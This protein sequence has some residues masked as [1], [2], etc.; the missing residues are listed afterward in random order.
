MLPEYKC[1]PHWNK[2]KSR[3]GHPNF[4]FITSVKSEA[5]FYQNDKNHLL[6]EKKE[7]EKENLLKKLKQLLF[8]I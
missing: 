8:L 3:G 5:Y 2:C 7:Q 6:W 4:E 1:E